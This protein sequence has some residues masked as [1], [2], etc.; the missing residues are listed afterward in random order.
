VIKLGGAALTDKTHIYTPRLKALHSAARQLTAI[1]KRWSV[2]LVHGAG[3]YGHIPVKIFGLSKGYHNQAQLRGLG[4]A[5]FRLLEWEFIVDKVFFQHKIPIVPF[6]TSCYTIARRGRILSCD[7][8]PIKAWIK[9]G[10]VP[11]TGGDIV[12]DVSTG[13]SIVSGDQLAAYLAIALKARMLI[14]ATDVDGI[15]DAD[16]KTR[17]NAHLIKEIPASSIRR[18]STDMGRSITDVTG[19]MKG[20]LEEAATAAFNGIPVFFVNLLKGNRMQDLA[21]G[22]R[23]VCSELVRG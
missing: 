11:S 6:L 17:R 12:S 10:C 15:F 9:L 7:I 5:K 23:V 13:F 2:I 14:F 16:P 22:R 20:K 18:I 1:K 19:G 4:E 3:S 21:L 8:D